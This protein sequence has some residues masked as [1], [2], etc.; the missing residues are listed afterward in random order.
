MLPKWFR[1][2][3]ETSYL[4]R[5]FR[6]GLSR[7]RRINR[8]FLSF[9]RARSVSFTNFWLF[10]S[11]FLLLISFFSSPMSVWGKTFTKRLNIWDNLPPLF[12]IVEAIPR[13][14]FSFR[15]TVGHFLVLVFFRRVLI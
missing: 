8:Y 10:G 2:N 4:I 13:V 7:K 5:L 12:A 11:E 15:P 1:K 3:R 14:L 6:L 9:A